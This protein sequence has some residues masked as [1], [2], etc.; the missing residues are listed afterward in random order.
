MADKYWKGGNAG[1]EGSFTETLTDKTLD[2]EAAVDNG[3]GTVSM[4]STGHTFIVGDYV[5]IAD[6]DNY[7]GNHKVVGVSGADDF[8]IVATYVAETFA[9]TETAKSSNWQDVFNVPVAAPV[10][11]DKIIFDE[12]AGIAD[13]RSSRHVEGK[14]WRLIDDIAVG[15]TGGLAPQGVLFDIGYTGAIGIDAENTI[16]A[17]HIDTDTGYEIDF[18]ANIDAYIECSEADAVTDSFVGILIHDTSSGYLQISSDVNS[19]AWTAQWTLIKCLNG[20]T[21]EIV[22]STNVDVI[23]TYNS[24]VHLIIGTDCDDAKDSD[25]PVDLYIGSDNVHTARV[26]KNVVSCDGPINFGVYA[27][28][29]QK[30]F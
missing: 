21:L 13:D 26:T 10:A 4:P 12:K 18:K 14:H 9:G 1:K 24:T 27:L 30:S 19:G 20:G 23:R 25:S 11:N 3:D 5:V 8:E 29:L 28:D 7:D 16:S 15:D 22:D 2:N 17:F 6:T